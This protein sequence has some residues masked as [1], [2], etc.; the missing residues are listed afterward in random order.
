MG[1]T[2]LED[3]GPFVD[4]AGG[5]PAHIVLEQTGDVMFAPVGSFTYRREHD[6]D[7]SVDSTSLPETDLA[8][9]PQVMAWFVSRHGRHT[10]AALVHDQ[11]V[12]QR[13]SPADRAR[14]DRVFLAAL[15]DLDVPPVRRRMMWAAVSAATRWETTPWGR[16]GILVWA[17]A[18]L[19]GT[20]LLVASIVLGAPPL[21]FV[22]LVAPAVAGLLW[23]RREYAAGVIA[24][25]ALWVVVIPGAASFAGYGAYWIAEQVVRLARKSR[26]ANRGVKLP[27]PVKL[28]GA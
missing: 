18:A 21:A 7:I 27:G 1:F 19:A 6:P 10:P 12:N 13:R 8:S 4:P 22:A 16:I 3:T 28:R 23:S 5:H 17:L 26:A 14:A 20:A 15:E 25:Y 24:G 11:L 2:W 9:I